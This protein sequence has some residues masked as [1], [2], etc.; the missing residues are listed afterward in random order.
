MPP[1]STQ[2]KASS[3]KRKPK[4]NFGAN[5]SSRKRKA[6]T[7]DPAAG[8]SS[9][10]RAHTDGASGS[11]SAGASA[12]TGTTD[13][14]GAGSA[15]TSGSAAGTA[16]T[17]T[18]DGATSTTP[19]KK[20]KAFQRFIRGLCGLLTQT[21]VLPS[22][23]DAQKHYDKRFDDVDDYRE[24]MRTLV[25]ESRTAVS[26][27]KDLA[28]KLIRDAKR[29]SGPIANE[30]ARI[31]ESHLATVFTMILKAGLQGFCPDLEGPVQSTYNQLHRHLAV[32]GF[33]FLSASFALSALEVNAKFAEDTDLLCD[34]YDN[35]TYGTLAQKTK[36][37]RC[38]PGS[39]SQ[40]LQHGAEYKARARLRD[41]RFK[42]AVRLGLRKPVQRMAFIEEAHSDDEYS[43]GGEHRVREKPGR[44]PVVTKFFLEE[45]DTEAE[46]YRKRNAKSGQKAPKTRTR[47]D[48]LIP[49]SEIGVILP[50]DVPVDFFTPE[51]YNAL[52]LKERARYANTGVA[53]PLEDFVFDEMHDGWKTLGKKEFMELYGKDV[54][55][56]YDI[57]SAEEIRA[58]PD[59]DAEDGE[60][61]EIDL[62]DTEDE[63]EDEMQVDED[64]RGDS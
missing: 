18:N 50:P 22:P 20:R 34:M 26:A 25:D 1:K 56:Q 11:T 62:E 5:G 51:F 3:K 23:V 14:G 2:P 12:S 7:A 57:P 49:A 40:S 28:T 21:D 33:Q 24:H 10:K 47:A 35:Y 48:P 52:T 17:N 38:R 16:G 53:F 36:M 63:A 58:L 41:V 59:S 43:L 6:S 60:E 64:L 37:E 55:D 32:S 61:V 54:L 44:N 46:V 29:I 15:N 9:Q 30:I 13:A 39:L 19:A 45:L 31:P 42:T 27:A 8:T 4:V